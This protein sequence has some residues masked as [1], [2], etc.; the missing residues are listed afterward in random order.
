MCIRDRLLH[1]EC[2]EVVSCNQSIEY[3]DRL[4]GAGNKAE[5]VLVP[6]QGHG[7]FSGSKYYDQV[8]DFFKQNLFV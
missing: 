7:L 2:D 5:L 8:I 6:G 1:G 4:R 3:A